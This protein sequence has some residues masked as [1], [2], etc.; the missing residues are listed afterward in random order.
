MFVP[1]KSKDGEQLI[2]HLQLFYEIIHGKLHKELYALTQV[3][4]IQGG[5]NVPAHY[6]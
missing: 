2:G 6:I 4:Y 5:L 3:I 1:V